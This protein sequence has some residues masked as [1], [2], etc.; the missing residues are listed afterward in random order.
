MKRM[1]RESFVS[2]EDKMTLYAWTIIPQV[3]EVEASHLP[4]VRISKVYSIMIFD[5]I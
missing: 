2:L 5:F 4:L 3:F 1:I